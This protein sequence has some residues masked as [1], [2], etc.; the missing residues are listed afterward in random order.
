MVPYLTGLLYTVVP[1]VA[2]YALGLFL[3][4]PAWR[5]VKE[6]PD[7]KGMALILAV[8]PMTGVIFGNVAARLASMENAAPGLEWR[9]IL[10]GGAWAAIAIAQGAIVGRGFAA[11]AKDRAAFGRLLVR[12]MLPETAGL[13]AFAWFILGWSA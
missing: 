10:L 11:V 3:M 12:S 2:G 4:R 1:A 9:L 6:Q 7:L 13:V 5:S 8:L